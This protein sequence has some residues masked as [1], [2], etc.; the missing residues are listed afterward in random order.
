MKFRAKIWALPA[1]AAAVFIVGLAI[2][3]GVGAR[4]SAALDLLRR[5]D[6]PFQETVFKVDRGVEQFR[7]T[8]QSAAAEG[9]AEALTGV[10]AMVKQTETALDELAAIEGKAEIAKALRA[11]FDAYQA[12][13][14]GATKA[15]LGKG[16]PGDHMARMQSSLAELTK[17]LAEHKEAAAKAVELS[18][19][20]AAHGVDTNLW[21]GLG[22]GFAVLL[23]LG[24][25]SRLIVRSVWRD[26]G[27][28][29]T[30]LRERVQR[31]ADGDLS[32]RGGD[33]ALARDD[34]SLSSAV[35]QMSDKLRGTVGQIRLS[36][37]SIWTASSEI[38]A[39]NQ[40]LSQRTEHTAAN[41]QKTAA[42]MDELTGTVRQSADSARQANEVSGTAAGAAERGGEIVAQVVVN[43]QEI[44]AASRKITEIIGVIDGIAFQTNILALNAA[45]EAARA[46]E[47]G[48]GFAVVA[49]EVRSLAQRS[50]Q[51]AKEIKSLIHASSEKVE[52]GTRLVQNAGEAMTDIVAGVQRVST[53]I[54]DMGAAT[55]EQSSGIGLVNTAVNELDQ[56]TQQ[57]SALV[58]ES[59][60]AAESLREQAKRL[61]DAVAA[62][63]LDG[64]TPVAVAAPLKV[65]Q[66]P[67][68]TPKPAPVKPAPAPVTPKAK[69]P[70]PAPT[71]APAPMEPIAARGAS[72]S[73]DWESF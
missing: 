21:V 47:Q 2:S 1:S 68:V 39:G 7:L 70:A 40:D 20:K 11:T 28:E 22:M 66:A 69:A 12:A 17:Q 38:A 59:A 8:L 62:F 55:A 6:Y 37:D 64:S 34:G 25:A 56:M 33:A 67:V 3:Y 60:A 9:D 32:A 51:A 10:V 24:I 13:G 29:P 54:A 49:S 61:T 73:D 43:M 30:L 58:E 19:D 26:L 14:L 23:V 65:A 27:D 52:S 36:A 16:E 35:A 46:G 15:I 41:L 18:Q 48:R 57:N 4:T 42:S 71:P 72:S 31:I 44:D 53:I 5:V 50:A 45:V 63:R